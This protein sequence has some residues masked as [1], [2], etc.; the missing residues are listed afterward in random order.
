MTM[1]FAFSWGH[2]QAHNLFYNP[3]GQMTW[4]TAQY[5][6]KTVM[7]YHLS[8]VIN[9]SQ[10][11]TNADEYEDKGELLDTFGENVN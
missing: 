8:L 3:N 1:D 4:E 9:Q 2:G 11:A 6:S 7:S 5:K 10:R